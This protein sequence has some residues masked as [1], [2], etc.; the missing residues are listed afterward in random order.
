MEALLMVCALVAVILLLLGYRR[1]ARQEQPDDAKWLF[2]YRTDA[3][4][5]GARRS[6]R[7]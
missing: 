3:P 7:R 4:A 5:E 2:S 6:G 1:A